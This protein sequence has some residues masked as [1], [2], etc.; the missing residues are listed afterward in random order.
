MTCIVGFVHEGVVYLAG[1]RAAAEPGDGLYF[2]TADPKIFTIPSHGIGLGYTTSFRMGQ[3]LQ[4]QLRLPELTRE[5]IEDP[6][7]WLRT[8]FVDAVRAC[9]AAGGWIKR[10][11][12]Q[13]EGGCFLLGFRGALYQFDN[14][15][16]LTRWAH[17]YA[18]VGSGAKLALG[19]IAGF[20]ALPMGI[21]LQPELVCM[22]AL[23]AAAAHNAFVRPPFD[24]LRVPG[25]PPLLPGVP[26]AA[27]RSSAQELAPPAVAPQPAPPP[28][29][30]L[31]DAGGQP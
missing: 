11:D 2:L 14:D 7:R 6:E 22:A 8:A 29:A 16:Q 31:P 23:Q 15:L 18:A 4:H 3:L 26:A 19:A 24:H 13:E 21:F 30:P 27:M 5:A 1:D 12:S 10:K 9:W 17:R 28:P 20:E 25:P